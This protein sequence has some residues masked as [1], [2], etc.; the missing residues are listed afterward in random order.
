MPH[1]Q[2]HAI[3]DVFSPEQKREVIRKVTDAMVKGEID[4]VLIN[5]GELE[6]RDEPDRSDIDA[7]YEQDQ[8]ARRQMWG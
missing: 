1:V 5:E 8:Q 7:L 4:K 6:E 2:V 3:K